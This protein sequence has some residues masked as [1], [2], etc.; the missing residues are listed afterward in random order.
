MP[1]G[2]KE[3]DVA[4]DFSFH[5]RRDFGGPRRDQSDAPYQEL[6]QSRWVSGWS[7]GRAEAS[8]RTQ[9]AYGGPSNLDPLTG[10]SGT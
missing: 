3:C 2:R 6:G 4:V 8:A 1:E 9:T 10:G 5:S 7:R